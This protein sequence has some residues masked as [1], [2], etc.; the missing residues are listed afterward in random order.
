[1]RTHIEK[2]TRLGREVGEK[3]CDYDRRRADRRHRAKM[4]APTTVER[5]SP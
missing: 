2:E 5:S 3:F 4:I 1:M